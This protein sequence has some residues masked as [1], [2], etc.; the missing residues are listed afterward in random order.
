MSSR[1]AASIDPAPWEGQ[2]GRELRQILSAGWSIARPAHADRSAAT[3][4]P[5]GM[6]EPDWRKHT[7]DANRARSAVEAPAPVLIPASPLLQG[8]LVV[9]DRVQPQVGEVRADPVR[10]HALAAGRPLDHRRVLVREW[11]G[12]RFWAVPSLLLMVGVLLAFL[13]TYAEALHLPAGERGWLPVRAGAADA[14][15]GVIAAS[16]LTFVGVVFTI[17]LVALQ[18]ASAQLSPRVL[19]T[20][21]RSSLTKV[22]FGLF[23]ATFAYA[24][25]VLVLDQARTVGTARAADSRAVTVASFLVAASLL[26]FVGYVTATVKLLQVSW[27]ITAVA[28][29]TRRA[30]TAN[31]PP[32]AAHLPAAAPAL[33]RTPELL[34]LNGEGRRAFGVLRGI[35]RARLVE[36]AR[37]HGCV[38][39]LIPRVGCYLNT[40]AVVFAVHGGR[41]PPSRQ[42]LAC[43]DLGRSRTLYQDPSFGLR[44]LVDVATQALSPALNQATTAAQVIDR[45]EEVLLRILRRPPATDCF[46]DAELAVRLVVHAPSWDE[47]LDLAFLE[48]AVDGASS[49]QVARR[50]LAAYESLASAAP[51]DLRPGIEERAATLV[52]LID[53]T[54]AEAV[55]PAARRP[56]P[57]GLG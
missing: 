23:L 45:L 30:V 11:R 57:L 40:E 14:I 43:V 50:L 34:R 13:T 25:T 32:S 27:V 41:T 24:M 46:V 31:F 48:I 5:A 4:H 7:V 54:T 17:T 10:V 53:A 37:R 47:L 49:P 36:I 6:K 20:F 19:R 56:D 52:G 44:Q 55:R 9:E 42:V 2:A 26:V 39:E 22:A 15:L 16:M 29:Q 33:I 38:L 18:L 1:A 3:S 8:V 51:P 35:D 12:D 28:D 21:V